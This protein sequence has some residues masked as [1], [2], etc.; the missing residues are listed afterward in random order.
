VCLLVV[1]K[2]DHS[3]VIAANRDEWLARPS[4]P[5]TVLRPRNPRILGGRDEL[6]GGTWL[7]VNEHGVVAGLTN[8]PRTEGFVAGRK[9]RG[10]LPMRLAA[11]RTAREAADAFVREI[12]PTDYNGSWILVGDRDSLHYLDVTAGDRPQRI[13]LQ[14]GAY[15]L[16]NAP[17]GSMTAK[18]RRVLAM[19]GKSTPLEEI[20][21]SHDREPDESPLSA[22][23]VHAGPTYGTRSAEIV[24][25]PARLDARP[26]I[27]VADGPSCTTPF[28]DA[29]DLWAESE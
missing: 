3:L 9:S 26:T 22:P 21:D 23:C 6:A 4:V 28:H 12:K 15:V 18:T 14:A 16:E 8:R 7:A 5:M 10:E 17:Y 13:D 11:H 2:T 20:L 27:L 24:T 1:I 19:I 25:V 29:T